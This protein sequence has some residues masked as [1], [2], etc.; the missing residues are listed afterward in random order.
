[1]VNHFKIPYQVVINK[2]DINPKMSDK[3]EKWAGDKFL[4]KRIKVDENKGVI[5]GF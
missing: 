2:W 1:L 5:R 4:G 3:I